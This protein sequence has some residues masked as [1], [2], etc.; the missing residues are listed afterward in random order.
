MDRVCGVKLIAQT[1]TRDAI[2]QLVPTETVKNVIGYRQAV[3]GTEINEAGQRGIQSD[4]RVQ[5]WTVEYNNEAIVEIGNTR[6]TVYRTYENNNGK[7]E[8][9]LEKRVD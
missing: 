1:F 6:Y 3:S 7:T 8:L 4:C 9:Y 2:G 5:V